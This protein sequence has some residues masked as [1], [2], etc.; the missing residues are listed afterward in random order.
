MP[1]L[2]DQEKYLLFLQN[3]NYSM[4]TILSY[5][6]DLAIFSVYLYFNKIE[7][8]KVSKEDISN[9]KGYLRSGNHLK[10]LDKVR[11]ECMKSG[12][13]TTDID[14]EALGGSARALKKTGV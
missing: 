11:R 13:D 5:A 7:F 6:R 4:Q 14:S 10:D 2:P 9:Y 3:N 8:K 1:S 12:L